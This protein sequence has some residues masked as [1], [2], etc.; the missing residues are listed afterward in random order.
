[1]QK[2]FKMQLHQVKLTK[3]DTCL[4]YALKRLGLEPTYCDHNSIHEYFTQL[5]FPKK[6]VELEPGTIIL[7]DKDMEWTWLPWK[8]NTSGK[9]EWKNVQIGYHYGLYEGDGLFSDCTRLVNPPH[10]T[11]RM[12]KL[13]EVKK[14]PDWILIFQEPNIYI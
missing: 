13:S 10:P 5:P 11:L 14:R 7:W 8:I 2:V 4:T 9:I 3:T 6:E 12:R 1:M